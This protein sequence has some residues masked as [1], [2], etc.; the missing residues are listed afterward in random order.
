MGTLRTGRPLESR[1]NHSGQSG[2]LHVALGTCPVLL[3]LSF[4]NDAVAEIGP[5]FR[6]PLPFRRVLRCQMQRPDKLD[7]INSGRPRAL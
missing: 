3:V 4:T 2:V 5:P 7:A 1:V 6:L